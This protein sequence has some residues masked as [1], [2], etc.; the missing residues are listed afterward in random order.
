L[1][2]FVVGMPESVANFKVVLILKATYLV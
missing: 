1:R 2:P